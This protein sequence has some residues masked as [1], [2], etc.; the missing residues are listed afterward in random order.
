[1]LL[2]GEG[3]A[4]RF[5]K[6]AL[7]EYVRSQLMVGWL[8]NGKQPT[9]NEHGI[10]HGRLILALLPPSDGH[11]IAMTSDLQTASIKKRCTCI[12]DIN[13]RPVIN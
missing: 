3:E 9:L 1:M 2:P 12:E 8:P 5:L 4:V 7:C 13:P 11:K 6:Q 10:I